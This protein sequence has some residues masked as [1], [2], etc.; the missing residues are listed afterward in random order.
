MPKF[1]ERSLKRLASCDPRLQRIA[2]EL[3]KEMDVVV[4]EGH[5]GQKAQNDAFRR[6]TSKLRWPNSKHNKKPSR[7]MDCAPYPVNWKARA[8]FVEMRDR[9]KKIAAR[10]GIKVRF[11]SWDL[12]HIEL[13]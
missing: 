9:M 6:G 2:H 11:I 13:V 4:L 3:I 1:S 12:P 10:L 5:R 7:A 8:R